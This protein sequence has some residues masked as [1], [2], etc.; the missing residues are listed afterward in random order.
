MKAPFNLGLLN[1]WEG[2]VRGLPPPL[3]PTSF[4]DVMQ[5][6]V[7]YSSNK[8]LSPP[9]SEKKIKVKCGGQMTL[10]AYGYLKIIY[11]QLSLNGHL[12]KDTS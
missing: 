7:I 10:E 4:P 11:S 6:T 1:N 12:Y 2:R 3:I 9:N 5:S 8:A